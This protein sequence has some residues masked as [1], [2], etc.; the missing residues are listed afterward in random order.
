MDPN[1]AFQY[2]KAFQVTFAE[3]ESVWRKSES[4]GIR[5]SYLGAADYPRGWSELEKGA[6]LVFS[7]RGDPVWTKFPCI[8]VV[9]SRTPMR[10]TCLWMQLELPR[11]L[12][13]E[14]AVVVSGGARGVDQWAHRIC[15]DARRPTV[16]IFPSGLLNTYPPNFD[17]FAARIVDSGGALVS[18]FPLHQ[19]MRKRFFL[20]RNRWIAG[21]SPLTFVVE[22]N[23]RSGSSLTASLAHEDQ[24]EVCTLP[25][26]P[27][28][29]QGLG[30]LDLLTSVKAHLIRDHQDLLGVFRLNK[31][32]LWNPRPTT[33]LELLVPPPEI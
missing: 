19:E 22:A 1:W 16:C 5:W 29:A 12:A 25:V 32:R 9:G 13:Q 26:F 8:S 2:K 3:C 33:S 14:E 4:E 11:F 21:M 24:R 15:M 28:S 6:P 27:R 18:T 30:N 20:E 10:D 17:A 23:R 31:P 7:Y